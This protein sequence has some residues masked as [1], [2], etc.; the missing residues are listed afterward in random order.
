[1]LKPLYQAYFAE[2][3]TEGPRTEI[4]LSSIRVISGLERDAWMSLN[5][6]QVQQAIDSTS[7]ALDIANSLKY[8]DIDRLSYFQY[9]QERV[10]ETLQKH[11]EWNTISLKDKSGLYFQ[12]EMDRRSVTAMLAHLKTIYLQ[13]HERYSEVHPDLP[14]PDKM[15]ASVERVSVALRSPE[16]DYRQISRGLLELGQMKLSVDVDQP[17]PT[18]VRFARVGWTQNALEASRFAGVSAEKR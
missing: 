13:F 11:P 17:A 9:K 6:G 14:T 7:N 8:G 3:S 4:F 5:E 1:M 15:M 2:D 18:Y 16:P 10:L 12:M